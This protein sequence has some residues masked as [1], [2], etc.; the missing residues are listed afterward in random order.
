MGVGLGAFTNLFLWFDIYTQSYCGSYCNIIVAQAINNTNITICI[1]TVLLLL[2]LSIIYFNMEFPTSA[3]YTIYKH[4]LY[5]T[6][7]LLRPRLILFFLTL[8]AAPN[9][10]K[11]RYITER[12]TYHN[13]YVKNEPTSLPTDCLKILCSFCCVVSRCKQRP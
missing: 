3:S 8:F 6:T 13:L 12:E 4:M 5:S 7:T 10:L 9:T 1:V 11:L 2:L